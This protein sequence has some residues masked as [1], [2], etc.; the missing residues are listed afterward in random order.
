MCEQLLAGEIDEHVLS[1]LQRLQQMA[2][3]GG[4]AWKKVEEVARDAIRFAPNCALGHLYLGKALLRRDPVQ[5]EAAF[6]QC[7]QLSPD[8]TTMIDA[9]SHIGLLWSNAGRSAEARQLWNEL[10]ET[11]AGHPQLGILETVMDGGGRSRKP[12]TKPSFW[13]KVLGRF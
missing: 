11:Y 12:P 5:A 2:E 9:K 6:E 13:Q 3:G 10:R 4:S 7:L 8:E 1:L